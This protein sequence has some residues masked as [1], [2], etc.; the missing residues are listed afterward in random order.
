MYDRERFRVRIVQASP[1]PNAIPSVRNGVSTTSISTR[2]VTQVTI[3]EGARTNDASEIIFLLHKK[4]RMEHIPPE[5]QDMIYRNPNLSFADLARIS[6]ICQDLR[7]IA[8]SEQRLRINTYNTEYYA[9]VASILANESPDMRSAALD[10]MSEFEPDVIALH[11]DAIAEKLH[12]VDE[13]V[14]EDALVA[15]SKLDVAELTKYRPSI[16]TIYHFHPCRR[17][18]ETAETLL[19]HILRRE[20]TMASSSATGMKSTSSEAARLSQLASSPRV[21]AYQSVYERQIRMLQHG[22]M[23]EFGQSD[24]YPV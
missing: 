19:Q 11:A 3:N 7:H 10:V 4:A 16:Q 18:R 12:D 9:S 20:T 21:A 17:T 5:I 22:V 15:L 6:M 23:H 1:L 8:E 24:R 14:R 13:L 2:C